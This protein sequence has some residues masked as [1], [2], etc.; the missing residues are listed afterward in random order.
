MNLD[1]EK[2]ISDFIE[3]ATLSG[4]AV[5]LGDV[6]HSVHP[7]PHRRP[8]SLPRGKKAVYVFTAGEVC[9]KVGK[10]GTRSAARFTSQHYSPSSSRSNLAKSLLTDSAQRQCLGCDASA[11]TIGPWIEAHTTRHHFFLDERQPE[12]LLALLEVFL[13][14][15]LRPIFEGPVT[16]PVAGSAT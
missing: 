2:L 9:L 16:T 1:S 10:A 12:E 5:S 7:A 13:R 3:V 6:E 8:S 4:M 11:G 15:K 14:C